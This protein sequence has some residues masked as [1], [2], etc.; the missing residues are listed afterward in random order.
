[1]GMRRQA[2]RD[3]DTFAKASQETAGEIPMDKTDHLALLY[4][5]FIKGSERTN[6]DET[7]YTH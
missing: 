7:H 4:A 6:F 3:N 5:L 1:M 2:V